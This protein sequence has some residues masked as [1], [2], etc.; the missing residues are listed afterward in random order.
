M[1][2][3]VHDNIHYILQQALKNLAKEKRVKQFNIKVRS[4]FD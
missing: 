4:W 2:Y 3:T 1:L